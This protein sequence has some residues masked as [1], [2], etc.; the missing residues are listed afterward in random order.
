MRS[1]R[2]LKLSHTQT[3]VPQGTLNDQPSL[4]VLLVTEYHRLQR[5]TMAKIAGYRKQMGLLNIK[6]KGSP[7]SKKFS[8][9]QVGGESSYK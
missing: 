4:P 2:S 8:L 7:H 6:R 1:R 5:I 9:G 3:S